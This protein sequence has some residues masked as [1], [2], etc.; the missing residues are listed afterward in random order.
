MVICLFFNGLKN[1][2]ISEYPYIGMN[3]NMNKTTFLVVAF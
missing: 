2:E 1:P 3:F